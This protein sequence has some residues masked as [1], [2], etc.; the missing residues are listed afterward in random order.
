MLLMSLTFPSQVR[1]D[2]G[3]GPP[4]V[5]PGA[6]ILPAGREERSGGKG[7]R[8][9]MDKV[10]KD[11]RTGRSF[12]TSSDVGGKRERV[13]GDG[14]SWERLSVQGVKKQRVQSFNEK[15][16]TERGEVRGKTKG[17]EGGRGCNDRTKIKR[18]ERERSWKHPHQTKERKSEKCFGPR[19]PPSV[20]HFITFQ[21]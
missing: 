6:L 18:L 4:P 10:E 16:Q 11:K 2:A 1:G 3:L 17:T 19:Q 7:L 13:D 8:R 5:G 20:P 12:I 9:E 14:S 21:I 15:V